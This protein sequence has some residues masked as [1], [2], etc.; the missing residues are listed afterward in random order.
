[1]ENLK[2][3]RIAERSLSARDAIIASSA[4]KFSAQ[5]RVLRVSPRS[6]IV[7]NLS[8][9]VSH[10]HLLFPTSS[11][12]TSATS[13]DALAGV[14]HNRRVQHLAHGYIRHARPGPH[15][16]CKVRIKARGPL[17]RF[18][19]PLPA[20]EIGKRVGHDLGLCELVPLVVGE[21]HERERCIH[22]CVAS[23]SSVGKSPGLGHVSNRRVIRPLGSW[24]T[25]ELRKGRKKYS[26]AAGTLRYDCE[27]CFT[28]TWRR[29]RSNRCASVLL[30]FH[31]HD[32]LSDLLP[33]SGVERARDA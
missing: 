31:F 23:A 3:A 1:M 33:P 9:P 24:I 30:T 16:H 2:Q 10:R 19:D 20:T 17:A 14:T 7:N 22:A 6:L 11:P 27:F 5:P 4:F 28:R 21:E 12:H 15:R 26:M 29:C 18:A 32:G 13:N 25:L 8:R